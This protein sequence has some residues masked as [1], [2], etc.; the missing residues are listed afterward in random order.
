MIK[1]I[2]EF[3]I[4]LFH[5]GEVTVDNATRTVVS[6]KL[7]DKC[8]KEYEKA[9]QKLF[10]YINT[11]A[12]MQVNVEDDE[13]AFKELVSRKDSQ[14]KEYN[15]LVAQCKTNEGMVKAAVERL[16]LVKML[17]GSCER[18]GE[19]VAAKKIEIERCKDIV[20]AGKSSL[21]VRR[22]ELDKL[23]MQYETQKLT[24]HS[25]TVV[26]DFDSGKYLDE[27]RH[28]VRVNNATDGL[29]KELGVEP[30]HK[31]VTVS[32]DDAELTAQVYK[33][34]EALG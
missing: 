29:R 19:A 2:K 30:T 20:K 17:E 28:L 32:V 12:K 9:N 13:K 18:M 23:K 3:F 24:E 15:G 21:E 6:Y 1:E 11:I 22:V 4:S 7:I 14:V 34:I 26:I 31:Q 27:L 33:D 5:V 10:S 16:K 25:E 8:E